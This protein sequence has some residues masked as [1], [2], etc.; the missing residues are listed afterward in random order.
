MGRF[1]SLVPLKG[2]LLA[3]GA[4]K[5][6]KAGFLSDGCG[7]MDDGPEF[8]L[9]GDG[10]IT[11]YCNDK[12]CSTVTFTVIN[13]NDCITNLYG[14]LQPKADGYEIE[15]THIVCQCA[16]GDGGFKESSLNVVRFRAA[17]RCPGVASP[18]TGGLT[19]GV[20]PSSTPRVT[21]GKPP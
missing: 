14:D 8:T 6:T 12:I 13:L 20:P 19:G 16:T 11:T 5:V 10:S 2:L 17:T 18:Q 1:L 15:G 21:S 9:R 7:F 4:A 3:L